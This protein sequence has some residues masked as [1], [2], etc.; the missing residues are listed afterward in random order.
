[1]ARNV[2]SQLME[3]LQRCRFSIQLDKSTIVFNS[4][5]TMKTKYRA[6]VGGENDLRTCMLA[7]TVSLRGKRSC[8]VSDRPLH[9]DK[10]ILLMLV[11]AWVCVDRFVCFCLVCV[12]GCVC[13]RERER[14]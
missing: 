14:D 1:M 11:L 8:T 5:T 6:A 9:N 13:L 4:L 3:R 2:T 10:K 12:C 7:S